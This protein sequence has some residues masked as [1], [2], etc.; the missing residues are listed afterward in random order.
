MN[1]SK[2]KYRICKILCAIDWLILAGLA[3]WLENMS[4]ID[5]GNRLENYWLIIFFGHILLRIFYFLFEATR[6]RLL[7]QMW[8]FIAYAVAEVYLFSSRTLAYCGFGFFQIKSNL[9]DKIVLTIACVFF[10]AAKIYTM[11]YETDEYKDGA[12][13]RYNNR[14]DFAIYDAANELEHARTSSDQMRAEAKL[15][16]AKLNR[17]RYG[18]DEDELRND[19]R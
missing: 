16:R 5:S 9:L 7:Y 1:K 15:E 2:I 11:Y 10:L 6:S 13:T 4:S 12:I 14:L 17:K 3:S 8:Y 19:Y 18:I